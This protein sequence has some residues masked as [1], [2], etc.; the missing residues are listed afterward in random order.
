M[1]RVAI[2]LG[3]GG[4]RS[5]AHLGIVEVLEENNIKMGF[6]AGSSGGAIMAALLANRVPVETIKQEFLRKR[7]RFRW[8]SPV[9]S[10]Q[11]FMSQANI[12]GILK[13][14]LPQY[15]VEDSEIPI[16]I[17]G[18]NLNTASLEVIETGD[19]ITAVCASTAFPGIYRPV[20]IGNSLI[21]D[22]GLLNNIPADIC[23]ERIGKRNVV[24]SSHLGS[25]FDPRPSAFSNSLKIIF[26]SIYIPLYYSR[27]RIINEY[28][29][30]ILEPFA[31]EYFSFRNWAKMVQMY[32]PPKLEGFYE[33]GRREALLHIDEIIERVKGR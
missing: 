4:A 29:D 9:L 16:A 32:S 30:V 21:A 1:K 12:A 5:F 28:S 31:D 11:G 13:A 10:R 22:G 6:F 3:G 7:R 20:K 23:R 2:A 15:N 33:K 17:M 14:L 18:T 26:N 25:P 24:I 19:I 8:F 27:L